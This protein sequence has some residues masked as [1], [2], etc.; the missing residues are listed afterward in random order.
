[1]LKKKITKTI[2]RKELYDLVWTKPIMDIS[3]K[4]GI[5]DRGLG[6]VCERHDIPKPSRDYWQKLSAGEKIEIPKLPKIKDKWR[7]NIHIEGS[8]DVAGAISPY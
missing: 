7:E 3:K 5:S 1:M 2:T 4:F 8:I 6:K